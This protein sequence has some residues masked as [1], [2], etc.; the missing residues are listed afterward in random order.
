[1]TLIDSRPGIKAA[2]DVLAAETGVAI[3]S[4]LVVSRLG[5]PVEVEMAYWFDSDRVAAMADRYR[6]LYP[7]H[8]IAPSRPL[9]GVAEALAAVRAHRGRSIVV[10][11]KNAR[12]A[13]GHVDHLGLD[14][15]AVHGSAWQDGKSEALLAE[16]ATILVGDHA[17]DMAAAR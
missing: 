3:D 12:D 13:Q 2:F 4:D 7:T 6:E 8:A 1:M 11:A 10:T 15:D 16:G 17:R 5:P 14:I 9:P